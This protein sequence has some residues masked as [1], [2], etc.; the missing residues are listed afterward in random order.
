MWG[1]WGDGPAGIAISRRVVGR[2]KASTCAIVSRSSAGMATPIQKGEAALHPA[3]IAR[4]FGAVRMMKRT[5]VAALVAG[6]ALGLAGETLGAVLSRKEGREATRKL[7]G[8][9]STMAEQALRTGELVPKTAFEH[10]QAQ[11]PR[12][13]EALNTALAR[14]PHSS[15][16]RRRQFSQHAPKHFT[17]P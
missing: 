12:A 5:Q 6:T 17:Q 7:L 13:V 1:S 10:Y 8:K 16:A 15:E 11:A 14:A 3:T 4:G 2:F 9:T